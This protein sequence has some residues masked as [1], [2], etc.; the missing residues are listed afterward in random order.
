M[1]QVPTDCAI[2]GDLDQDTFEIRIQSMTETQEQQMAET[3]ANIE[4]ANNVVRLSA[5]RKFNEVDPI[6]A[7][8]NE[9]IGRIDPNVE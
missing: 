8:A 9:V 3:A 2:C 5:G 6:Q 1:S 4:Q 7:A